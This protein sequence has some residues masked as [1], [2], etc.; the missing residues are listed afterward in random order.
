MK[1]IN[2]HKAKTQ[3]SAVLADIENKGAEY[4]ICR[5]GKPVADL[6]P[7]E[8]KDRLKTDRSLPR[9]KVKCD[10]TKPLTEDDWEE[11]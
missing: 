1:M 9:V 7:H 4:V 5:N 6:V 10:L 2:V 3:L 11:R 8:M